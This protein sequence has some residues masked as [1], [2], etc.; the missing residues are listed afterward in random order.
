M[1]LRTPTNEV[2][3]IGSD[4]EGTSHFWLQRLTAVCNL[5]LALFLVLVIAG[6]AGADYAVAKAELNR[7]WI[8]LP[9][10]LL[11]V[12]GTIHMRIGMQVIV[13]DYVHDERLKLTCLLLNTFFAIYIAAASALAILTLIFGG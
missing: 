4:K 10:L 5:F 12:S 6:L 9:L 7:P 1:S 11:V 8:A 13:E 2:R 3:R